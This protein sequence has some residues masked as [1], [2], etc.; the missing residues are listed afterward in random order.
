M[1]NRHVI[2][3]LCRAFGSPVRGRNGTDERTDG[4]RQSRMPPAIDRAAK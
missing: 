3:G 2:F 1:I 4:R